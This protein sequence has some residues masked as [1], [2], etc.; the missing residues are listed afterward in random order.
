MKNKLATSNDANTQHNFFSSLFKTRVNTVSLIPRQ[1]ALPMVS[2]PSGSKMYRTSTVSEVDHDLY[3]AGQNEVYDVPCVLEKDPFQ[4][5]VQFDSAIRSL[6]GTHVKIISDLTTK[7]YVKFRE[8]FNDFTKK[9]VTF[10]TVNT[11]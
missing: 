5:T 2:V 8:K 4:S 9:D 6:D 11:R 3:S 1:G 10:L 7:T